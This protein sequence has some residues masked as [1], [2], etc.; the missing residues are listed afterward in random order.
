MKMKTLAASVLAAALAASAWAAGPVSPK[1]RTGHANPVLDFRFTADPTSVE[2]E[3]RLYVYGT[4]D[5][6]QLDSVGPDAGNNTYHH[7]KTLAMMS[8]DDMANWTYHGLIDVA[9]AA[10]WIM[11]SWA[12]SIVKRVEADGLTHFYLYYSDSGRGVGVLTATSPVGPWTDP[13]GRD[14]VDSSTPGLGRCE[15]PFDPGAVID[16]DGTGWLSFGGGTPLTQF[17][18]GNSRIARLGSDMIS[19]DS[20]FTPIDAPYFFEASELNYIDSTWVYTYNTSWVERTEWPYDAE[21]PTQ[22]SMCYMTS[23]TPLERDSWTFRHNY[24]KNPGEYGYA[25]CNNHTHL[26]KY[27]DRWYV[28]YHN[29]M[30]QDSLQVNA[31][32]RSI[33]IDE[34]DVR[35]PGVHIAPGRMTSEG[36]AQL[37]ALD[38]FRQQQA[39][40]LAASE[41][42]AFRQ[43]AAAGDML[44]TPA[45]PEG[46]LL[47][48]GV[49]FARAPRSLTLHASGR[50]TIEARAGGAGGRLVATAR[51]DSDTL[52]PVT[53]DAV[54]SP[55]RTD[56]CFVLKGDS[57]CFDK[58]I[59]R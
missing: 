20:G 19:F 52:Q 28:L 27:K 32:M 12:P 9:A 40:T 21:R 39:E 1:M 10:P 36:P 7:I 53:V 45:A 8:T 31:G 35:E 42:I 18:P 22:C 5:H 26:Q 30:L 23:R 55:G 50:G 14:L 16:A 51:I 13:L 47:L 59:F 43:G 48:R 4:N 57:L 15:A 46:T 2:H 58:W 49:D 11:N 37:Q 33:C 56:L 54:A 29:M 44:V 17:Q 6:Q 41:G 24:L 38:P 3:G 34:I 25:Y